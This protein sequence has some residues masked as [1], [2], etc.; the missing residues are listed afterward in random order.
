[1]SEVEHSNGKHPFDD[2]DEPLKPSK[3]LKSENGA[4]KQNGRLL[5]VGQENENSI[6][7]EDSSANNRTI[8]NDVE[9]SVDGVEEVVNTEEDEE[10]VVN[11]E[12]EASNTNDLVAG[13]GGTNSSNAVSGTAASAT[14]SQSNT[15]EESIEQV[16]V[17]RRARVLKLNAGV[18]N[19]TSNYGVEDDEDEDDDEDDEDDDDDGDEDNE[20]GVQDDLVDS[21]EAEDDGEEDDE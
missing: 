3:F 6:G 14:D 19:S 10:E 15:N 5:E 12:E 21:E 13:G 20:N 7:E 4:A 18:E 16:N 8:L 11:T 17:D 9:Q 1:M 2:S